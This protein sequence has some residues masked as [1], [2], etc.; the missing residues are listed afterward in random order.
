MVLVLKAPTEQ[1]IQGDKVILEHGATGPQGL[2][3]IKVLKVLKVPL[4][5]RYSR[6]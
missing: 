5:P 4:V 1:G 3:V 6:C 2:K